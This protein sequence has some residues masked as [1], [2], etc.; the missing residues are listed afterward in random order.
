MRVLVWVMVT[1]VLTTL[2]VSAAPVREWSNALLAQP[3][4]WDQRMN[5]AVL[6]AEAGA[7]RVEVAPER[8]WAIAGLS[9]VIIPAHC[10]GLRVTVAGLGGGGKWLVRLYGDFDGTGQLRTI[11]VFQSEIRT[12]QVEIDIDPRGLGGEGLP[13]VMVQLGLEGPAGSWATFS[14]MDFLPGPKRYLSPDIPGQLSLDA[15][16]WMPNLPEPFNIIDFRQKAR[17]YDALV[18][19]WKAEGEFLP[20]IWLDE[21]HVN[22]PG[23]MFGLPSYV[24]DAAATGQNHESITTMGA[25]LGATLVGIDKSKQEYDYVAM[26]EGY[27]NTASGQQLVLNRVNTTTGGS[28]WYELFPHFTFYGLVDKYPDHTRLAEIMRATAGR[29]GQAIDATWRRFQPS[30]LR[31]HYDETK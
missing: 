18:F 22:Y 12:G 15:V 30:L 29:W 13:P 27:Y 23:P 11:G 9:G 5:G 31:L 25:V 8:E 10:G 21:S 4:L 26:T 3:E 16:D 24:G 28:F 17:D 19:D 14:G 1:L 2:L 6:L 7:L 20:L